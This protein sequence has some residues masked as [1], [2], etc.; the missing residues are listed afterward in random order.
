MK[1]Y[2]EVISFVPGLNLL[3]M[4]PG[5]EPNFDY[6]FSMPALHFRAVLLNKPAFYVV[7]AID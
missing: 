7:E 2:I 4:S 5:V 6:S 1:R 3:A